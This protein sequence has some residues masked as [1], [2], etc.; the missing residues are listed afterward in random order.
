MA[1]TNFSALLTEEK[2]VWS[3]DV[4]KVARNNSFVFK[5]AG[6]SINSPIHRITELTK[7]ER[8]EMAVIPLVTDLEG[9][10]VTGDNV[11]WDKEE[12]LKAYDETIVI[13]QLRNANRH[14]GRME[15]QKTVIDFREQS[16]DKLGYWLGDRIDQLGFLTLSGVD[17]RL[18]NNGALRPGFTHNGTVYARDTGVS[19]VGYALYDLAYASDVSAPSSDRHYRWDGTAKKLVAGDTALVAVGDTP[20]YAMLV[21]AKALAKEKYIRGV[22]SGGGDEQY[23]IFMTPLGLAKLKLDPDFLANVRHAG[24]RGGKNPIFTGAIET[25]DGLVI[26]EFR[27]VFNTRGATAGVLAN[28]GT[29]GFKWGAT[30]AVDGQRCLLLGAQ[31]LGLADLGSPYWNE[32]TWDYDNQHGIAVGKISG[33]LKPKFHSIYT[34]NVQDFGVMAIDCAL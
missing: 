18:R 32:D 26:H 12:E 33:F 17:Y 34:G 16:R 25:I 11:L 4:W 8:G 27:H 14:K 2:K 13:D 19:A 1:L 30:A 20:S 10:G 7:T 31:A 5:F 9:D 22:R 3:R 23:H 24:S 15:H 21:E 28:V 29:P 6:S